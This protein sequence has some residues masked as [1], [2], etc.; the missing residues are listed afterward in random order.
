M[1]AQKG[2][3]PEG[4]EDSA[5]HGVPPGRRSVPETLVFRKIR[6]SRGNGT[7]G[8]RSRIRLRTA[9]NRRLTPNRSCTSERE[10]KEYPV[11]CPIRRPSDERPYERKII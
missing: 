7:H 6:G 10:P 4:G 8:K 2:R 3:L 9:A 11:P 1:F 5:C